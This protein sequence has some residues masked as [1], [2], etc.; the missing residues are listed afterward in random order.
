MQNMFPIEVKHES[1]GETV[2]QRLPVAATDLSGNEER[3]VVDAV[4]SSWISSTGPYMQRFEREFAAL[5]GAQ[6]AISV[7]NGTV[8]LHLAMLALDVRPGDEVLV[9]SLT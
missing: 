9:P 3:Y 6:S 5:T 7:C 2:A 1:P 4:R 8:A